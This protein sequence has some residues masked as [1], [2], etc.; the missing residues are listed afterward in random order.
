[1]TGGGGVVLGATGRNFAAG[2]SGGVAYVLDETGDLTSRCNMESVELEHVHEANVA[3][4][5]DMT[6]HDEGRLYQ[7]ISQHLHYTGS[8]RAKQI[9]DNWGDDRSKF[10]KVVPAR[11]DGQGNR[12]CQ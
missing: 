6:G 10:R 2:M 11:T 7:L 3:V 8:A 4:P 1:M 12:K 5:D 9:L